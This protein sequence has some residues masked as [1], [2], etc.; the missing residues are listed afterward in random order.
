MH[1]NCI[2]FFLRVMIPSSVSVQ[3]YSVT[4]V[5]PFLS[6]AYYRQ[7][8]S[9]FQYKYTVHMILEVLH[10]PCRTLSYQA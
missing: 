6:P 10:L 2:V 8:T 9:D 5:L 4:A 1:N 7:I 3:R